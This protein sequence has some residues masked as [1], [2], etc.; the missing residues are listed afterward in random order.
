MS[1]HELFSSFKCSFLTHIFWCLISTSHLTSLKLKFVI[2]PSPEM[3]LSQS[4]LFQQMAIP[5]FRQNHPWLFYYNSHAI[6]NTCHQNTQSLANSYHLFPSSLPQIIIFYLFFYNYFFTY[7]SDSALP[8]IQNLTHSLFSTQE[9]ELSFHI[10]RTTILLYSNFCG[11]PP[12]HSD[13]YNGLLGVQMSWFTCILIHD[14]SFNSP[15]FILILATLQSLMFLAY[16]KHILTLGY[17]IV[18]LPLP[19]ILSLHI[20]FG[21][22]SPFIQLSGCVSFN[23]EFLAWQPYR[24]WQIVYSP[25]PLAS[26][27]SHSLYLIVLLS[28]SS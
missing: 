9:A 13:L 3:S 22:V 8:N 5:S 25:F 14:T 28:V 21:F 19:V 16:A 2:S 20:I 1:G 12:P 6:Y 4:S 15:L 10:G 18:L 17:V 24:I 27:S 23:Q 26:S 11:I 7:L